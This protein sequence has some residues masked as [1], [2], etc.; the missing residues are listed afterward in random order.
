MPPWLLIILKYASTPLG[1]VANNPGT[2]PVRSA[3]LPPVMLLALT[4]T[5]VAPPLPPATGFG[6]LPP[7]P[8]T[9]V[10]PGPVPPFP[11]GPVAPFPPGPVTPEPPGPALGPIPVPPGPAPLPPAPS[12]A[13]LASV[14]SVEGTRAPQAVVSRRPTLS[15][16]T[17]ATGR[18]RGMRVHLASGGSTS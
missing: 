11:P 13:F 1:A 4:P 2:G 18:D 7:G 5:S 3:T 8:V 9:P 10:P 16:A 15:S 6:W 17:A 14:R 12:A